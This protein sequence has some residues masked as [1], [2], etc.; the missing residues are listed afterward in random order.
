MLNEKEMTID[1]TR[2]EVCDLMLA[3]ATNYLR[4][5][6]EKWVKLHDKLKVVRDKLDEEYFAEYFG[7][8]EA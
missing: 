2:N 6:N 1:L 5:H 3:C 8:S 7:E 4:S